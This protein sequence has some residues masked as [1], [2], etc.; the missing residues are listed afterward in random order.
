MSYRFKVKV[1]RFVERHEIYCVIQNVLW[2]TRNN[3]KQYNIRIVYF[4]V[5]SSAGV[6]LRR[7]KNVNTM[8]ILNR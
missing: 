3:G 2:N 4:S 8:F 7:Q 5:C 6:Y 1:H